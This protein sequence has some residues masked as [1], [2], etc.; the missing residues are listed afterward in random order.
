ML[1]GRHSPPSSSRSAAT[2]QLPR[3]PVLS[4]FHSTPSP[5]MPPT[6]IVV[7]T[8]SSSSH[9]PSVPRIKYIPAAAQHSASPSPRQQ[10]SPY[11]VSNRSLS[12]QYSPRTQWR[13]HASSPSKSGSPERQQMLERHTPPGQYQQAGPEPS[14]LSPQQMPVAAVSPL[15]PLLRPTF[16]EHSAATFAEHS[17]ATF[18][19]QMPV[20]ETKLSRQDLQVAAPCHA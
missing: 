14:Q 18:A 11:P 6:H 19:E 9:S 1:N 13:H 20:Q 5:T 10:T 15:Q 2:D 3:S 4:V 16:A 12:S 8:P 7:S 17:A